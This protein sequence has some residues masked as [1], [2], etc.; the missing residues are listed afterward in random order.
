MRLFYDDEYAATR[1]AIEDGRGYK[2]TAQ[3]LWPSMKPESAYS[4]LKACLREDKPEK[5]EFG[6]VVALCNFNNR[7]DPLAWMCDQTM[8]ERPARK[9][10]KDK[11]TELMEAYFSSVETQKGIQEEMAKIIPLLLSKTQP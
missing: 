4:R 3:H 1:A 2:E 5:L 6:E 8:H 10:A 11:A 7:F 9:S